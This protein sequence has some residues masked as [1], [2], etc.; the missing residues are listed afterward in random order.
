MC[1][2]DVLS[3]LLLGV[4]TGNQMRALRLPSFIGSNFLIKLLHH[5]S[6]RGIN[7]QV[8]NKVIIKINNQKFTRFIS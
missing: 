7:R 4:E 3:F 1:R 2:R 8:K 6:R 5:A